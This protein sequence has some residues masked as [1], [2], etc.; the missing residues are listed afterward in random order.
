MP[1]SPA[2]L[3]VKDKIAASKHRGLWV[4][5]MVPLGYVSKDRKIT[6]N[7]DEAERV[8]TVFRGYLKLGSLNPLM[9]EL[10]KQ[11]IVTKSA[12]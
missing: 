12:P 5:G 10:R 9:A 7:D 1:A 3:S 4:G 11:G 8:R 6:V 2:R